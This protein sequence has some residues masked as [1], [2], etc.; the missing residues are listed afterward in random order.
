MQDELGI[1]LQYVDLV[2]YDNIKE[3]LY[4]NTD[5][6]KREQILFPIAMKNVEHL[7]KQGMT[8]KIRSTHWSIKNDENGI[9]TTYCACCCGNH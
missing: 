8:E 9:T 3:V 2:K 6:S 5:V 4:E 1:Y 7:V